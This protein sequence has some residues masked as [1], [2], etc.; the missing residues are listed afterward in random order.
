MTT[1]STDQTT[2]P[3]EPTDEQLR[4]KLE[5]ARA[6]A[7]PLSPAESRGITPHPLP[8]ASTGTW[9]PPCVECG[10]PIG[11]EV[12]EDRYVGRT[13]CDRCGGLVE[14]RKLE[15]AGIPQWFLDAKASLASFDD[16]RIQSVLHARQEAAG[17]LR[18]LDLFDK[19]WLVLS[20]DPG[21]GKSHLAAAIV[22]QFI[23]NG[24]TARFATFEA[25]LT[26]IID[27]YHSDPEEDRTGNVILRYTREAEC[28]AIDDIGVEVP[29][30][31]TG[32]ILQVILNARIRQP[33][34]VTSNY[35]L[36]KKR[37]D[38]PSLGERLSE[39]LSDDT[40]IRRIMDRLAGEAR[41]V[42]IEAPSY[43]RLPN[44]GVVDVPTTDR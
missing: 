1:T 33:T 15:A 25:I 24:R 6:K 37:K 40:N 21:T 10:Q 8:Q 7:G 41:S 14:I 22:Q 38:Q 42:H 19:P 34:I 20:G 36:Q 17:L 43:R 35:P 2:N 29:T 30:A 13:T 32:K 9:D 27:S 44:R 11:V 39:K 5:K 16:R 31:H 28:L 3:T 4:E 23:R 12:P 26:E 18:P